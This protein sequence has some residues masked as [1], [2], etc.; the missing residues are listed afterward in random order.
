MATWMTALGNMGSSITG[1]RDVYKPS[2]NITSTWSSL[3]QNLVA[4]AGTV[5]LT[6]LNNKLSPGSSSR[7]VLL[8]TA[9][10]VAV[11]SIA[12]PG[13][14][15]TQGIGANLAPQAHTGLLLM[16]AAVVI[17]LVLLFVMKPHK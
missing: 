4:V 1:V 5:G 2:S 15:G 10:G 7:P 3:A 13:V 9:S 16:A 8:R 17:G 14:I 12:Q 6:A 11:P